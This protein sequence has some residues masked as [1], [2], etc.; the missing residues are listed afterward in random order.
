MIH[1]ACIPAKMFHALAKM[2]K[3]MQSFGAEIQDQFK[4]N[5]PETKNRF[6]CPNGNILAGYS[7]LN[8]SL[9]N[10]HEDLGRHNQ[11]QIHFEKPVK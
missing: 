5:Q 7:D 8:N 9:G 4:A 6:Q 11:H 10:Q 1:A 3:G 2:L